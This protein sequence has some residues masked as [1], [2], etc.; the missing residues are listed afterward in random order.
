MVSGGGIER[1]ANAMSFLICI[2]FTAASPA[3]TT[4]DNDDSDQ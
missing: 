2:A 3:T 4:H 1:V